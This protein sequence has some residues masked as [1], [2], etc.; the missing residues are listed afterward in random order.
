MRIDAYGQIGGVYGSTRPKQVRQKRNVTAP[1]DTVEIS[2]AAKTFGSALQAVAGA[3]DVREDRVA[4]L[5]AAVANGTYSVS[6]R[7]IAEKL[8]G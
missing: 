6:A 1:S 4:A 8:V 2:S 3:S 5:K 7:D